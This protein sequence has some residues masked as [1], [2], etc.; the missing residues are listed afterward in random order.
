MNLQITDNEN[1]IAQLE[2]LKSIPEELVWINNFNSECSIQTYKLATQQFIQFFGIQTPDQLREITHAH[3]I[4]FRNH[5]KKA[6]KS[7]RTINNRALSNQ[8]NTNV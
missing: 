8:D 6:E 4:G 2:V 3:I 1:N 7:P 5:L